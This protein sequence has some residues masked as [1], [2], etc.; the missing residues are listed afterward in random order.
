MKNLITALILATAASLASSAWAKD[1]ACPALLNH[2]FKNLKGKTENLCQYQ[3]KVVLVVN[4]ASFCG[5]TPQYKDLQEL[6][7][8][9]QA[10]GLVIL[11]FPANDF[12][13][14]EP[15]SDKEISEFCTKNFQV[16][17]PMFSKSSV[18]GTAINPLFTELKKRTGEAPL[19]NFHKYLIDRK[20]QT[21]L[22]FNSSVS[23][24]A[25]QFIQALEKMLKDVPQSAR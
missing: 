24:L 19:W 15:G 10:K 2:S 7:R 22:S 14:Q 9:Y 13:R 1:T 4:T 12:G 23:P 3:N 17:F 16:S 8:K 5:Y 25:P 20:T 18:K 11:G 21:V 6:Y